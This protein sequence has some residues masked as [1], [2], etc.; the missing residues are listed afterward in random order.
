LFFPCHGASN[1]P[2]KL[3]APPK[4]RID[5]SIVLGDPEK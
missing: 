5:F 1:I 2:A 3:Y 4:R